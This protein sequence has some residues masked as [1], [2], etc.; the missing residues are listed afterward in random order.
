MELLEFTNKL[1]KK[2]VDKLQNIIV[3]YF[4]SSCA[5]TST[6][7]YNRFCK[8]NAMGSTALTSNYNVNVSSFLVSTNIVSKFNKYFYMFWND[9]S[10]EIFD[11]NFY[12]NSFFITLDNE[13]I[14]NKI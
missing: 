13:L 3:E 9:T 8:I 2:Y 10:G 6:I 5:N 4:A 1:R 7:S 11:I 12:G 14:Y